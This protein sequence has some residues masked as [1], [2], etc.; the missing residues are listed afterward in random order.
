M[1]NFIQAKKY[2]MIMYAKFSMHEHTWIFVINFF[3][4]FIIRNFIQCINTE[5][6]IWSNLMPR[7]THMDSKEIYFIVFHVLFHFLHILES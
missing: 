2:D 5:N 3:N 1:S 4:I 7:S 6:R